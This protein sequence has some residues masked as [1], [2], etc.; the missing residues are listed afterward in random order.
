MIEQSSSAEFA[1]VL[2]AGFP[3]VWQL[4]GTVGYDHGM[5]QFKFVRAHKFAVVVVVIIAY[6]GYVCARIRN[7]VGFD[8]L[9]L[10]AGGLIL[11]V[12]FR[13]QPKPDDDG[14]RPDSH[15]RHKR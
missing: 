9:V 14:E 4:W 7:A 10:V 15:H 11:L 8:I 3:L 2:L 1:P 12:I 6:L 13:Y 5:N